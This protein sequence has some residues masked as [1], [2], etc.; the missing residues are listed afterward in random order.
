MGASNEWFPWGGGAPNTQLR[1]THSSSH[2]THCHWR[3]GKQLQL[4]SKTMLSIDGYVGMCGMCGDVWMVVAIA[5]HPHAHLSRL[6]EK[7][8]C[9]RV[10]N[11]HHFPRMKRYVCFGRKHATCMAMC[12]A[13]CTATCIATCTAMCMAMC[14]NTPPYKHT[15]PH[16]Q[17]QI[18]SLITGLMLSTPPVVRSQI[19]EALSIV[20]SHDFPAHWPT[21]LPELV[22]KLRTG[23]AATV[24]GVLLTAASIFERYRGQYMSEK[25]NKELEY[26]QNFV[27]PLLDVF[28]GL[29]PQ[30]CVF[31]GFSGGLRGCGV[32]GG[33]S[34]G[35]CFW[36]ER[37]V[38]LVDVHVH[39]PPC[40]CTLHPHTLYTPSHLA[41]TLTPYIHLAYTLHTLHTYTIYV[42][43]TYTTTD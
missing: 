10:Y 33:M 14:T 17:A 42:R 3:Y 37:K 19:S 20:S 23:D 28:V 2:W 25:L 24:N 15:H 9:S 32:G 21:L 39:M 31:D 34:E 35:C 16:T 22:E 6:N 5:F 4:H 13:T 41:Y 43:H 11:S 1:I 8:T 36:G 38:L 7:Q 26:S 27:Q 18:K 40:T 30:V 12:I 29:R